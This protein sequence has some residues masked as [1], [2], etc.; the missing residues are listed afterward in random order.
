MDYAALP[1]EVN[2]GR[3]Y[4]GPGSG[5]MLAAA[6]AWDGLAAELYLTATSYASVILALT[7]EEWLGPASSSMASAGASHVAWLIEVE[8][9]IGNGILVRRTLGRDRVGFGPGSGRLSGARDL[10]R[11]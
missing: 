4:A 11:A 8:Q 1:P 9:R 2:S 10:W 3:M 7:D 5:P 6:A